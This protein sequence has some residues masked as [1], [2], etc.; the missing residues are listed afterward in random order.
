MSRLDM[1]NNLCEAC[2]HFKHT[3]PMT[4]YRNGFK[5]LC[6]NDRSTMNIVSDADSCTL[7]EPFIKKW[8][9]A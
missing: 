8:V 5:G 1:T 9:R 6:Y 4:R 7:F 2:T 3:H